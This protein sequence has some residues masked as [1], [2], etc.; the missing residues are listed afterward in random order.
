MQFPR[1][2]VQHCRA[3]AHGEW[4]DV[5]TD[6]YSLKF[7]GSFPQRFSPSH[8]PVG[9]LLPA[10]V[11]SWCPGVLVQGAV[12]AENRFLKRELLFFQDV[13]GPAVLM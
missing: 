6:G 12:L 5:R 13:S 9:S 2:S 7:M 8:A 4:G 3:R 10:L 1:A 11:L